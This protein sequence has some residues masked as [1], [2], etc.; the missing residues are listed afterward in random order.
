MVARGLQLLSK[1][2]ED[3][4]IALLRAFKKRNINVLLSTTIL[5]S[6]VSDKSVK[7]LL[8]SQE[9]IY[10]IGDCI[11]TS[12]L[13]HIACA[14]ARITTHN[15]INN[16]KTTNL[17][18]IPMAVFCNPLI[19]SCG[20]NQTKA[21]EKELDINVKNGVILGASIIGVEAT[22]IIHIHPSVSEIIRY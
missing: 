13:A 14:E 19:A 5:N 21:K 7:L 9:N 17:H 6:E 10:A 4:A 16:T 20:L 15:I 8:G 1:E 18:I 22:E 12:A 2:D 3:I 11:N